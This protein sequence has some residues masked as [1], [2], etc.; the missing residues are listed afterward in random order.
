MQQSAAQVDG[1]FPSATS[2]G[3]T[4][5]IGKQNEVERESPSGN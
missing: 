1:L 3:K 5:D 4:L 2:A